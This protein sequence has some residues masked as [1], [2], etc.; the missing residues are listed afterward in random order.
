MPYS[1]PPDQFYSLVNWFEGFLEY[2]GTGS[3]DLSGSANNVYASP[4][5][6]A[7]VPSLR[8]LVEDDIPSL[9]ASKITSGTLDTARIPS[10]DT[11]KVTSGTFDD[12]RIPN[13]NTSK[14]TAGIFDVARIPNLDAGLI[15]SGTLDNARINWSSPGTIG[16][17]T[18]NTGRF[19][20]LLYNTWRANFASFNSAS[21]IPD[22]VSVVVGFGGAG[23]TLTLPTVS[24]Y[25]SASF[26]G[27]FFI[28]SAL[29]AGTLTVQRQ[30]SDSIDVAGTSFGLTPG[31]GRILFATEI[32]QWRSF[33][34]I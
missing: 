4:D 17:T 6:S 7:G 3:L 1:N 18:P 33:G 34:D 11:S 25:R 2:I 20:T 26:S 23:F 14:V 31:Q 10:L 30:G 13:L 5:G 21:T 27:A 15:T 16:S 12:A 9:S 8:A 29:S 32:N 22:G 24:S 28:K 19:T